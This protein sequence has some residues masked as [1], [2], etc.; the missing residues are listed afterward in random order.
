MDPMQ[1]DRFVKSLA[2]PASR[3]ATLAA[4]VTGLLAGLAASAGGLLSRV[5]RVPSSSRS[6]EDTP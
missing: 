3:R 6:S 2:R 1:F 5:E 4:L